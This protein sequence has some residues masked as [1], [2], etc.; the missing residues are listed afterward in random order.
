MEKTEA[1]AKREELIAQAKTL[2]KL[3]MEEDAL[4][5]QLAKKQEAFNEQNKEL[6]ARVKERQMQRQEQEDKARFARCVLYELTKEKEN[7]NGLGI[8]VV[9][10]VEFSNEEAFA[11]ALEHKMALALD[12]KAFTKIAKIQDI[13]FVQITERPTATISRELGKIQAEEKKGA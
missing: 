1:E 13:P 4:K 10:D 7:I 9:Q 2:E 3:I 11:W 12:N 5:L 8:R 6:I